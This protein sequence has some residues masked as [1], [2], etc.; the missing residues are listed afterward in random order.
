[1]LPTN[2]CDEPRQRESQRGMAEK[3]SEAMTLIKK[4]KDG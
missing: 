3:N 2:I 4:Y 1:M